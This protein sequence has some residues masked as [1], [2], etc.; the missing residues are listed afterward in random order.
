MLWP[1]GV[2]G[3]KKLWPAKEPP[4]QQNTLETLKSIT[5]QIYLLF[6]GDKAGLQAALKV[7]LHIPNLQGIACYVGILPEGQDPDSFIRQEGKDKLEQIFKNSEELLVYAI[8]KYLKD[9]PKALVPSLI[10]EKFSPWLSAIKDPVRSQLL[11]TLENLTGISQKALLQSKPIANP[12]QNTDKKNILK[13]Q[14]PRY[15][16]D[17][18]GYLYF[19]KLEPETLKQINDFYNRNL[20]SSED[21][22]IFLKELLNLLKSN[23][24]PQKTPLEEW[25]LQIKKDNRKIGI[26][27]A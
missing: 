17:L 11:N 13:F 15:I 23:K 1:C 19:N 10:K 2:L 4:S 16:V 7:S 3:L 22:N 24:C 27:F 12:Q 18:I 9:T 20:D 14:G 26:L 25:S 21:I 6:D 8:K 5:N